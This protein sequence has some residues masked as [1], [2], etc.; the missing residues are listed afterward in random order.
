MRVAI[1][2]HLFSTA[3][4]KRFYDLEYFDGHNEYEGAAYLSSTGIWYIHTPSEYD[5]TGHWEILGEGKEGARALLA[6]YMKYLGS[7]EI[8]EIAKEFEV[9]FE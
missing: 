4:A 5:A 7:G 6:G 9:K 1:D 8:D 2:G 3:K